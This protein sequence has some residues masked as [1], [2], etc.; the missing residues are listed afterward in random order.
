MLN[1]KYTITNKILQNVREIGELIGELN[2]QIVSGVI[3]A[4]LE[5]S[6]RE[7]STFASVSIE[8]NPLPLTEV[9]RVLKNRP[10]NIRDSQ[11]E[12]LNYNEAL[13]WIFDLIQ[14]GAF[15]LNKNTICKTQSLVVRDLLENPSEVGDY[16]K[17]PVVV[18]DPRVRDGIAYL[19]PDH[20]E[21]EDLMI[22]LL[23][24][25]NENKSKIDPL[26]LAGIF[27]KQFV[28]I[29]PFVDGNGRTTRLITTA[30]LA[31]LGLNTFELFSFENYYHNNITKYFEKVG[32]RGDYYELTQDNGVDFTE[33]LEYF[34]DG[35]IDEL[36]R[37]QK[38][39]PEHKGIRLQLHHEKILEYI[40][41]HGSISNSEYETITGRKRAT[42]KKD[43]QYLMDA[44][45]IKRVG[46]SRGTYYIL[47]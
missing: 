35:I 22:D 11:R 36:R 23:K 40:K 17:V 6:A 16:R 37:V 2:T 18:H 38:L 26:L 20:K 34:T 46:E 9:R 3:K 41:E 13:E 31:E 1:P 43:L 15:K 28:I 19:A 29:H 47:K 7:L 8:G 5:N 42:R 45:L 14:K 32:L 30:L 21:V 25:I 4:T 39:I 10:E 27:H 24:Y 12:V 33:W 44:G